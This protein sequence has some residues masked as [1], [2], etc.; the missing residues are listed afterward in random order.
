MDRRLGLWSECRDGTI[1]EISKI[2]KAGYCELKDINLQSRE[3]TRAVQ[4]AEN[5][6]RRRSECYP[7]CS[8]QKPSQVFLKNGGIMANIPGPQPDVQFCPRCKGD[9]H[10]VARDEMRSKGYKRK[11]GTVSQDTHT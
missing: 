9:L 3:G 5:R 4:Q 2:D 8:G 6:E 10:N 11:D 1:G 7:R